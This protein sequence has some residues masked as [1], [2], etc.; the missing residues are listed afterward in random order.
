M[1]L[2]C[3]Y[4][5]LVIPCFDPVLIIMAAFSW[6]SMA[7]NILY[8]IMSPS[9]RKTHRNERLLDIYNSAQRIISNLDPNQ[10]RLTSNPP[11]EVDIEDLVPIVQTTP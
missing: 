6:W 8:I 11:K 4:G 3:T 10:A 7:W 9:E 1:K 2:L 5:G